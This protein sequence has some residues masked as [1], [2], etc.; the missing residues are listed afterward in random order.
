MNSHNVRAHRPWAVALAMLLL[1]AFTVRDAVAQGP[2][3]ELTGRITAHDSSQSPV[4]QALVL[5]EGTGLMARTDSLGR[6][7]FVSVPAGTVRVIARRLG[8]AAAERVITLAPGRRATVDLSLMPA[9][10]ELADIT[11]IGTPRDRTEREARLHDVAGGVALVSGEQIR[12]TRAA[13]LKDA[14]QFTP[15]VYVQP[16]FGAADESQISIRGS[17]L[18]GNFHARGVNL[19]VNGMPYRNAD[20]FTDFESLELLTADAVEVYRG[21][22]ALRFGGSTMGGAI[23]IETRTGFTAPRVSAFAQGGSSGYLKTQL[24]AGGMAGRADYYAS[25]AHTGLSGYRDWSGQRRERLNLHGGYL[26]SPKVDLRGFYFYAHVNEQLPGA[27]TAA[28]LDSTPRRAAPG[29]AENRWGR[30]YDLHHLG[31]QLRAEVGPGQRLEASPY[32]QY[33]DIDHPIFQV[34]NQQSTDIGAEFRYENTRLPIGRRARL[35]LGFQPSY[36]HMADRQFVNDSGGHGELR[37][38]QTDRVGNLAAYGEQLI[39][40]GSGLSVIGGGRYEYSVRQAADRYLANGDQSDRR[41]FSAFSPRFGIIQD[42]TSAG[43]RLFANASRMYEPPLL[44]ELN[45]F[46]QPGF[47]DL[48]GQSAWQ[49]EVGARGG[50]GMFEWDLSLYDVELHD[51]ILNENVAP[52]P[53]AAFTVPTYRNTPRSRHS[54]VE[55]GLSAAGKLVRARVAYT[56]GHFRFVG[57]SAFGNN[58]IPGAPS[59]LINAELSLLHPAGFTLTPTLDWAPGSFFVNSENTVRNRGWLL[60]GARAEWNIANAGASLF[61]EAR[62]LTNTVRSPSVQ[63]DNAVG[64]YFEPTDGRAVYIGMRWERGQ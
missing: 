61:V 50:H 36:M 46:T 9:V 14:L 7:R 57:D 52:F 26:L 6:Y 59:H 24:A 19:L 62:N 18:R 20:G 21:A 40:L 16:R 47:I 37:K 30:T 56:Y 25:Y 5:I 23:N 10:T 35:T 64:R 58:A 41:T 42:V 38:D 22:N 12:A 29:N 34:I 1:A 13:N 32:L 43:T 33:R 2:D 31:A 55:L 8:Y 15:G 45:S 28:E 51:E 39:E 48:R 49:F 11:V 44:L 63:V 27:L 60:L 4:A 17:G 54:G 3:A 53:G